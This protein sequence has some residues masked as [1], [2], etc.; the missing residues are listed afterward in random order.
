MTLSNSFWDTLRP[1]TVSKTT[2]TLVSCGIDVGE[3][4]RRIKNQN[5]ETEKTIQKHTA[6]LARTNIATREM[7]IELGKEKYEEIKSMHG[8]YRSE[9]QEIRNQYDNFEQRHQN[10]LALFKQKIGELAVDYLAYH[11]L[12]KEHQK[13]KQQLR[14]ATARNSA[15]ESQEQQWQDSQISQDRNQV[16]EMENMALKDKV[17]QV[18]AQLEHIQTGHKCTRDALAQLNEELKVLNKSKVKVNWALHQSLVTA[19]MQVET[20]N[21]KLKQEQELKTA[22][23]TSGTNGEPQPAADRPCPDCSAAEVELSNYRTHIAMH[24]KER[25]EIKEELVKSRGDNAKLERERKQ[26][27]LQ[28]HGTKL[29]LLGTTQIQD[30][31]VSEVRQL[32]KQL[33]ALQNELELAKATLDKEDIDAKK[34][35]RNCLVLVQQQAVL[36]MRAEV[37]KKEAREEKEKF[38]RLREKVW[39]NVEELVKRTGGLGS[40]SREI[41]GISDELDEASA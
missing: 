10:Q 1:K 13:L 35:Q 34:T 4:K 12:K 17:T 28:L 41:L 22:S 16:L 29:Q 2:L 37:A 6:E 36:K 14:A 19:C 3:L 26:L 24:R 20:L 32:R 9:I 40:S 5:I 31:A 38:E 18:K 39:K 11:A 27:E 8:H 15:L 33:L 21:Q 25:A 7:I 23:E 30:A